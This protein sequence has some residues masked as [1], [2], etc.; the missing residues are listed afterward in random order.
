MNVKADYWATKLQLA[1]WG[2]FTTKINPRTAWSDR[3]D[4][5]SNEVCMKIS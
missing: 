1:T 3:S 2:S 5:I 4:I